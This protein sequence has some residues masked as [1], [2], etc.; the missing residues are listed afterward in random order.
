MTKQSK[1]SVVIL[2]DLHLGMTGSKPK[3]ILKF[4]E[5]INTNTL[6]LNG[7]IIDID[8][9]KRGGKWKNS[10]TKVIMKILEMSKHT[11]VIYIRGNHDDDIKEFYENKSTNITFSEEYILN[12][13]NKRYLIF[14]GDKIDATVKWKWLTYIGSIGYDISI[15]INNW[16]N[17]YR[18]W[19]N[20]PYYSISKI[21]KENFKEAISFINNFESNACDYAKKKNCNG[22]ICGHIHVPSTKIIDDIIYFNSGDWVENFSALVLHENGSWE[23]LHDTTLN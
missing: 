13:N 15:K 12:I 10:H 23:L 21:I 20:K 18:E 9:L 19:R 17:Q 7:D 16:Y 14:H 5:S 22:V 1:Y 3:K 6:I 4:L 2:S 11:E 8:A